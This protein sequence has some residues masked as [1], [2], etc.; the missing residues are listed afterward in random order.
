SNGQVIHWDVAKGK[1]LN[2]WSLRSTAA[3][4]IAPDASMLASVDGETEDKN[5]HLWDVATGQ[6]I[7]KLRGHKRSV[8]SVAFSSDGKRIGSGNPYEPILVWDVAT[9][10]IL[11]SLEQ[12]QGG[13]SLR[14]SPDGNAIAAANMDGTIRRWVVESGD[15]L[16]VLAGYRGWVNALA[17][18]PD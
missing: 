16:P 1:P 5:V 11:H 13:L 18:S 7:D 17:F 6:K 9:R 8:V 10:S 15:E 12:N 14:F 3:L 2:E 4:A